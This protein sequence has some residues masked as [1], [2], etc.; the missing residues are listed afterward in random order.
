MPYS[1]HSNYGELEKF[2]ASIRP[3]VL[4]CV[5]S[6]GHG[7]VQHIRGVKSISQY[8]WCLQNIKQR[9]PDFFR[10]NYVQFDKRSEKYRKTMADKRSIADKIGLGS[11]DWE[12]LSD[13]TRGYDPSTFKLLFEEDIDFEKGYV[14]EFK[15]EEPKE[16]GKNLKVDRL[17]KKQNKDLEKE[18]TKIVG[19]KN[20]PID[21]DK[22]I[23]SLHDSKA[24]NV[25]ESVSALVISVGDGIKAVMNRN[26]EKE[27]ETAGMGNANNTQ[28]QSR[29]IKEKRDN[30][31]DGCLRYLAK[32]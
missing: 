5:V 27:L 28:K 18:N 23:R 31:N 9:G 32:R 17:I 4:R 21:Q 10:Q 3:A 26:R 14:P 6:H 25:I 29:K 11:E 2:V 24:S 20:R 1:S 15:K 7:F 16:R 12:I 30:A 19:T 22:L 13:D 8:S